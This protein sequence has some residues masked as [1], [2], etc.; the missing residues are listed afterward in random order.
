MSI[1]Y[2]LVVGTGPTT[3]EGLATVLHGF[4]AGQEL[5][6]PGAGS[7]DLLGQGVPLTSRLQVHVQ[8]VPVRNDS[9]RTDFGVDSEAVV[10]LWVDRRAER[11]AQEAHVATIA[12]GLVER[13]PD[14]LV[15]HRDYEVVYLVRRDGE[16][17]VSEADSWWV[18]LIALVPPPYEK[19]QLTF[20]DV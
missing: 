16:V 11:D 13:I 17:V 4:L 12:T 6:A 9:V 19:K 15:L 20:T 2:S 3:V 18:D 14:D 10:T 7:A 8:T 5:V 1:S